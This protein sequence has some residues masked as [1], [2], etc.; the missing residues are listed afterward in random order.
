MN[1]PGAGA[2]QERLAH[3]NK[4]HPHQPPATH[5]DSGSKEDLNTRKGEEGTGLGWRGKAG[6]GEGEQLSAWACP[7]A[8]HILRDVE[9]V[10]PAAPR[11]KISSENVPD[12]DT[13]LTAEQV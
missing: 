10:T 1:I 7:A 11:Q 9:Q 5:A 6:A 13:C 2:A 3:P 8:H 12:D 4:C